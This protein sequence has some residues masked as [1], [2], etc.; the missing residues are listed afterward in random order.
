MRRDAYEETY[1]YFPGSV[2]TVKPL[3]FAF[4]GVS[5]LLSADV[6]NKLIQTT[7]QQFTQRLGS[8][9]R[10]KRRVAQLR[11]KIQTS[12]DLLQAALE[13]LP[14]GVLEDL[15]KPAETQED[16]DTA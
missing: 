8:K 10:H 12:P 5:P 13:R 3:I 11:D 9:T 2:C 16:K 4:E 7:L 1:D 6:T 14:T 15:L